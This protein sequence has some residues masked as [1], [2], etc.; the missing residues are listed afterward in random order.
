MKHH[1][2]DQTE[3][4][5]EWLKLRAG[6]LT[7]SKLGCVMANFGKAFGEP[8]KKY[9]VN[10][11]IEQITGKPIPSSYS[12]DAMQEG[13][14]RE[15]VAKQMYESET[16]Q[17]VK[18]GGFFCNDLIGASPDGLPGEGLL[19][20]KSSIT[21][22]AHYERIRKQGID[23]AYRWQCIGTLKYTKK[24]WLDF[25]SYCEDF[26]EG[27]QLFIHRVTPDMFQTE[28]EQIDERVA[29]FFALVEKSKE[30]IINSK[31]L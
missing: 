18:N 1:N 14:V 15:P 13:H 28:F 7:M 6:L 29:Q 4:R 8:A 25:V 21:S 30:T 17:T 3:Q 27:K 11:A 16:F 9:A 2:V 12:N 24:P 23:S 19:E 5:E 31:Y 10:I 20:I 22:F 26:P